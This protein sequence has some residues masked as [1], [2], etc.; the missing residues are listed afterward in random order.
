MTQPYFVCA[1]PRTGSSLL[2]G[3]LGSTGVAGHPQA[4]FR[5]PDEPLWADRWQ[6]PRTPD[7]GFRY[8]DYVRAALAAGRTGNG[9]FGAKLMWGTLDEVVDKLS[10]VH[11]ELA[12]DDVALLDRTFGHT[13]FIYLR[14]DDV[15]AQAVSWLRAEQSGT[16]YVDGNGETG[17]ADGSAGT[18]ETFD[19]EGIG[20]FTDVI[21]Q[22]NA[23]WQ[24]WFSSSR[25]RPHVV[26]YEDLDT[27]M[28]GTTHGILAFLGLDLPPGRPIV[29]R[30]RRQAD[31]VTREWV[32]R[33]RAETAGH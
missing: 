33:Y 4:Y 5:A 10:A 17:G 28:A 29:A 24:A 15:L 32:Q 22:H 1:T 12:G 25:I 13:R 16:W 8:A 31:G 20:H 18:A 11:P 26:R 6:L 14:R 19:A 2:L 3:L 27:D 9:V 21:R 30:H 7:G 23:A